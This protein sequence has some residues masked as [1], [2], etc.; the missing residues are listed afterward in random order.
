MGSNY[1]SEYYNKIK[2]GEYIASARVKKLYEKLVHD[3]EEPGQYIFDQE[4]AERPIQ[5]IERFC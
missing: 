1:I 5:F 4:R 2:S 3:L